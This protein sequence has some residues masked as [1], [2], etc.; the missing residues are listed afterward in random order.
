M[1][2]IVG[3]KETRFEEDARKYTRTP[4]CNSSFTGKQKLK[5][6]HCTSCVYIIYIYTHFFFVHVLTPP[7]FSVLTFYINKPMRFLY[8]EY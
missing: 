3:Y 2:K 1:F 7:K 5:L 6:S 8:K 4:F